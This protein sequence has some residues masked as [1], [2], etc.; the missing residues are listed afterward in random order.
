M[1]KKIFRIGDM[2]LLQYTYKLSKMVYFKRKK[3][4]NQII[5]LFYN[6]L[7]DKTIQLNG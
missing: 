2:D 5:T 7:S 3:Y 1:I 6:I 4:Y